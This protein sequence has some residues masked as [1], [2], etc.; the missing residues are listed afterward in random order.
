MNYIYELETALTKQ[1]KTTGLWVVEKVNP[2]GE[3][4]G[5]SAI[6]LKLNYFDNWWL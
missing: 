6:G 3:T 1:A 5:H 2:E 4:S